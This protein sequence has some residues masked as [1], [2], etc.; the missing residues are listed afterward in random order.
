MLFSLIFLFI[1]SSS[2]CVRCE[3]NNHGTRCDPETG[4]C[5]CKPN[6]AGRNCEL[7]MKGFYGNPT[8]GQPDDCKPCPCIFA[9]ECILIGQSVKCTDCPEGHI[10]D[11]CEKC[12]DGYFGDPEGK[13]GQP[14][15]YDN[16]KYLILC[17]HLN[18]THQVI[19]FYLIE[20][21]YFILSR[22]PNPFLRIFFNFDI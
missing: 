8:R 6:T 18:S 11:N 9:N 5:E 16:I 17:S 12:S 2:R 13:L 15:R 19:L 20:S 10:G 14:T 7:C 1:P 3:C 4:I 22:F 21:T